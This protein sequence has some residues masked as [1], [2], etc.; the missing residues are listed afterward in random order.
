MPPFGE[1]CITGL[2][3]STRSVSCRWRFP[4]GSRVHACAAVRPVD[5][6]AAE[7]SRRDQTEDS[8]LGIR[9]VSFMPSFSLLFFPFPS[10]FFPF[11]SPF[12]PF[13]SPFF[14][15]FL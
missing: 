14:P 8:L 2:N 10:P 4:L 12:F 15:F 1:S 11:P 9:F 5:Q 3:L 13:P 6:Y 7:E